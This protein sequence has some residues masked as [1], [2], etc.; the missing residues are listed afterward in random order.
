MKM[1]LMREVL[2]SR[3]NGEATITPVDLDGTVHHQTK[4][5]EDI[6]VILV[7]F[8]ALTSLI[9]EGNVCIRGNRLVVDVSVEHGN[10]KCLIVKV[11]DTSG[12]E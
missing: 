7:Y 10:S 6:D 4:S 9:K 2:I 11:T 12:E 1:M 3:L 8:G 5:S